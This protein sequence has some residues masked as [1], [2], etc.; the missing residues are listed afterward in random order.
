MPLSSAAD[1]TFDSGQGSTVYSDSQSSQQSVVMSTLVDAQ[2]M[3]SPP[4]SASDGPVLLHS[5][6]AVPALGT[7]Q[8]P[9]M[10]SVL[11]G[12]GRGR[13]AG[14]MPQRYVVPFCGDTD[15]FT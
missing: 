6:P 11:P 7:F 12:Q 5:V 10:V 9:P 15:R 14:I 13:A 3:G 1:S 2:G 8:Q 4:V